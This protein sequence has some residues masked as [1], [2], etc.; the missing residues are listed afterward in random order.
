MKGRER[1]AGCCT[2][3]IPPGTIDEADRLRL[4]G[5]FKALGDDNRFD[6]YRLIAAQRDPICACDVVERFDLSQPTV[7][8][9][10]RVLSEAGLI[11]VSRRGVWAYYETEPRGWKI[12]QSGLARAAALAGAIE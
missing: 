6:I 8:H 4:L 12:V 11:R 5:F 2:V 1:P 7:S 10:L 3:V 9:H